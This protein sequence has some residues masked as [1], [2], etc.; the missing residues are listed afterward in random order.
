MNINDAERLRAFL[1]QMAKNRVDVCKLM[2]RITESS[3]PGKYNFEYV[4]FSSCAGQL[5]SATAYFHEPEYL[6]TSESLKN[7]QAVINYIYSQNFDFRTRECIAIFGEGMRWDPSFKSS[8]EN[9]IMRLEPLFDFQKD[10]SG[11]RKLQKLLRTLFGKYAIRVEEKL[12]RALSS[13]CGVA[14]CSI[15]YHIGLELDAEAK[16]FRRLRMYFRPL[17]NSMKL[18]NGQSCTLVFKGLTLD[19]SGNISTLKSYYALENASKEKS[20]ACD[21][22]Q[23]VFNMDADEFSEIQSRHMMTIRCF[24]TEESADGI[25]AKVYFFNEDWERKM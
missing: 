8:D 9:M 7:R 13:D 15:P 19:D 22:A 2:H 4:G 6:S 23:K 25:D 21:F 12:L 24:A 10:K 20:S 17:E 11:R 5:R 14:C 1:G 16:C 3:M 18:P